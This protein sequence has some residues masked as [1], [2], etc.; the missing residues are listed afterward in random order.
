MLTKRRR[1]FGRHKVPMG[2]LYEAIGRLRLLVIG[3]R[4][5]IEKRRGLFLVFLYYLFYYLTH[6]MCEQIITLLRLNPMVELM[7]HAHWRSNQIDSVLLYIVEY[8]DVHRYI[9]VMRFAQFCQLINQCRL[10]ILNR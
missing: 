2:R 9:S 3:Y 5:G 10:N 1:R 6:R 4:Q 8:A 7:I